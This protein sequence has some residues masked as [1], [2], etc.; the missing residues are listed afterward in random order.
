MRIRKAIACFIKELYLYPKKNYGENIVRGLVWIGSWLIG[1]VPFHLTN[2]PNAIAI[3]GAYAIYGASM[4]LEFFPE[5]DNKSNPITRMWH[6]LFLFDLA[7]MLFIAMAVVFSSG[8]V[9]NIQKILY[10]PIKPSSIL[11]YTG[12]IT[13]IT[14]LFQFLIVLCKCDKWFYDLDTENNLELTEKEKKLKQFKFSMFKERAKEKDVKEQLEKNE[15]SEIG[16]KEKIISHN[17]VTGYEAVSLIYCPFG[18][19]PFSAIIERNN[20]DR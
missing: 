8:G 13:A 15:G 4:I 1:I 17:I 12:L 16:S 11:L 5:A 6:G 20:S 3:G 7:I 19:C 2:A 10:L 18:C 9:D 14:L